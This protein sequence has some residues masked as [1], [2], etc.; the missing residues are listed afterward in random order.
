[1]MKYVKGIFIVLTCIFF[2]YFVIGEV[3]LPADT[4]SRRGICKDYNET[5]YA[6]DKDGNREQVD[7][8][9][10]VDGLS[11]IETVLPEDMDPK[12]T[13]LCFGGKDIRAYIDDELVFETVPQHNSWF[14][15]VTP[16]HYVMIPISKADAGKTLRIEFCY[17]EGV[18]YQMYIG[19]EFGIWGYILKKYSGELMVAALT[20]ILGCLTIIVSK[21]YGIVSKK[22]VELTYL[23]FGVSFAAIW[24]VVNS[25]YRQVLCPNLSIASDFPFMMVMLIPFPFLIYMNKIQERRFEKLYLTASFILALVDV[26][27]STLYVLGIFELVKTF[28]LVAMACIISIL[29]VIYSFVVDFRSGKIKE[30]RYVAFGLFGAFSLAIIQ[31]VA[32]FF[33]TGI[34]SG[35]YLAIG[36]LCLLVG[37]AIHTINNIFGIEKDK[38]AALMASEAKGKF[39]SSMSHEIR[40]PI[41]AILGMDE[42][43]LREVNEN[44]IRDYALDIQNAGKSLLALLNDILD[45]SKI[46]SGKMEI[47]PV[48]YDMSS[49]LNDTMNMIYHKA[50]EKGLYSKINVETS[51][52]SRL[53][54]DDL[55][56]RQV[57]I[58]I[59]N[60]AV[61]YTNEGGVTLD[62]SSD[63]I[64]ENRILLH[65]KVIDTG[66]GIKEEDLP[67]L[68][69][70]FERIEEHRNRAIEGTGLGM[71]I[72]LQLLELM[73]TKLNVTSEYSKG[74]C[75]FFDLEQEIVDSTPIG[76]LSE[77]ISEQKT[78]YNYQNTFCVKDSD[79]L[80][81]DDN[82]VNRKV[83]RSLLKDK[84]IRIHEADSGEKCL[85]MICERKYD[86]IFLD[87]MMPGMDGIQTLQ[88]FGKVQNNLNT[89]TP[90]IALTA[91]AITG[92]REMYIKAGFDDFLTKPVVFSKLEDMLLKYISP[93]KIVLL[94]L[95]H[96]NNTEVTDKQKMLEEIPDI[97]L[98]YALM[99]SGNIN[100]VYDTVKDFAGLI[101]DEVNELNKFKKHFPDE[102][103]IKQYRV[104]V[105]SIKASTMLIGQV[106]LGGVARMLEKAAINNNI[107]LIESMHDTF[108]EELLEKK[109]QCEEILP[110]QIEE[111]LV[112][113]NMS[114]ISEQLQLL[115][116]AVK[117]VDVDRADEIVELLKGFKYPENISKRM[118]IIYSA[119]MNLDENA[120]LDEIKVIS[121]EDKKDDFDV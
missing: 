112:E 108:V 1:M 49:M 101:E 32:Y 5:I 43:I 118:E 109:H 4:S 41:N 36:M 59:L 14:S 20:L 56:I 46:E 107:D 116:E 44:N 70:R 33:R 64:D 26:L 15:K 3:A 90:V 9:S 99:L 47:I 38:K 51:I 45:V 93:E 21:I 76:D 29:T 103:A 115:Y 53:K 114:L 18:F 17:D 28:V 2:G 23:G 79:I 73:S 92:A 97:N 54:G 40:T 95:N 89:A 65:F 74:S 24:L 35:V 16:E 10:R 58:N 84:G 11:G 60:N 83:V 117:D 19:T 77:R 61:K 66:I 42:M 8:I 34:F 100:V 80:V 104:K 62:V 110:N 13:T 81:V 88:Q 102:D 71:N 121:A 113:A 31:I 48:E 87:H 55:R 52:P 68:F 106:Y 98:D 57:L 6:I 91:N 78:E 25:V 63:L 30:Y 22:N 105:H 94:T 37:A 72:S 12:T 119:V 50:V 75:F 82:S 7:Q 86:I 111:E 96:S 69:A 39:L 120:V 27:N 67:K 85:E